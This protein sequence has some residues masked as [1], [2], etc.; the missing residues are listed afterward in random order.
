MKRKKF[1][2]Q[3]KLGAVRSMAR[4]DPSPAD[5][6]RQLGLPRNQLYQ[7]QWEIKLTGDQVFAG[8]PRGAGEGLTEVEP[9]HVASRFL[10]RRMRS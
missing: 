4:G 2:K 8:N 9:L 10:R 3:L 7:W 1:T 6:A 5:P